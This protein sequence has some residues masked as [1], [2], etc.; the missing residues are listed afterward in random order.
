MKAIGVN[1]LGAC[2]LIALELHV[3]IVV[4]MRT[5]MGRTREMLERLWN[6]T[7]IGGTK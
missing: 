2:E 1:G 4:T 6:L 3:S 7:A 5:E